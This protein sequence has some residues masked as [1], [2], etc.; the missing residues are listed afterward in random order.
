MTEAESTCKAYFIVKIRICSGRLAWP[1]ASMDRAEYLHLDRAEILQGLHFRSVA[2]R[3]R[4]Y[5]GCAIAA[6]GYILCLD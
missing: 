6:L 1:I 2:A 4:M 3:R 5:V